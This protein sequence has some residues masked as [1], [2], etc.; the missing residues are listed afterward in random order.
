MAVGFFIGILYENFDKSIH[1]FEEEQLKIVQ[2]MDYK[3][4]EY[5]ISGDITEQ[6]HIPPQANKKENT[7]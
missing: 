4:Q 5:L 1:F 7:G 2:E 6:G 3:I